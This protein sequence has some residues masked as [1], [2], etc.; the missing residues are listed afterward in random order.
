M[1][2]E[3]G[4]AQKD[5]N[6]SPLTV[7]KRS[8]GP[9]FSEGAPARRADADD[10]SYWNLHKRTVLLKPEMADPDRNPSDLIVSGCTASTI[11]ALRGF[12]NSTI[13]RCASTVV[14]AGPTR[15]VLRIVDCDRCTIVAPARRVVMTNCLETTVFCYT[16]SPPIWVGDN[17]SCKFGPHNVSYEGLKG[18][19]KE[20]GLWEGGGY[21]GNMWNKAMD[22]D[23]NFGAHGPKPGSPKGEVR[24]EGRG[25]RNT[26]R[27]GSIW[28]E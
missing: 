10:G 17:R 7:G 18:Q 23:R 5:S 21:R 16:P 26:P 14:V 6:D 27:D 4:E 3:G 25:S 22:L 13:S 15:G 20:A 19:C 9:L 11:Y 12:A 28:A 8:S 24:R 1:A 2:G